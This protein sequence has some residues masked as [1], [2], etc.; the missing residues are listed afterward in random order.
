MAGKENTFKPN[1][2]DKFISYID[3]AKGAKRAYARYAAGEMSKRFF[4]GASKSDRTSVWKRPN[5]GPNSAM[6]GQIGRLRSTVRN[7]TRNNP[8]SEKALRVLTS[9]VVKDGIKLRVR[10]KNEAE[11]ERIA[12][13]WWYWADTTACDAEG[14]NDLYGLQEL[15]FRSLVESGEV[16]IRRRR[17]RSSD[18][19]AMPFQLQI[20]EPDFIDDTRDGDLTGGNKVIQGVEFNSIGE[21]VAYY[22]YESHPGERGTTFNLKSNR[23]LA[24]DIIH[25]YEPRR[26]GQVRGYPWA[27]PVIVR[28]NEFDQYEDA[29]LVKQRVSAAW[30][31]FIYDAN[32]PANATGL[33][34][35]VADNGEKPN[36][37]FNPGTIEYL[38]TGK[39]IEFASPPSIT[40]YGEYSANVLRAIAAGY[41]ITYESLTGDLSNVNFASARVGWLEFQRNVTAWQKKLIVNMMCNR[42]WGWFDEYAQIM[43]YDTGNVETKWVPPRREMMD[44]TKEGNA[45]KNQIRA[46][47]TSYTRGLT[48]LGL[49]AD[50]IMQEI[51]QDQDKIKTLGITIE[52]DARLPASGGGGRPAGVV[53]VDE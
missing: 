46:G 20:L 15:A 42:I 51:K 28:L 53:A 50:E 1:L 16:L 36:E 52:A 25:L 22:L 49:D 47:L 8:W 27:A 24:K 30:C 41:G 11:Q 35:S 21:R 31:A 9:N 13:L 10:H 26:P 34:N 5:T 7:L 38:P 45:L 4:E 29:Q 2:I 37:Y 44:P 32:P 23:V 19:R 17:R 3:P 40:G 18:N 39:K 12:L 33:E 14:M 6:Y 43:G 48:E